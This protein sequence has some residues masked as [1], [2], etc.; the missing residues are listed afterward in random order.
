M[1]LS[2]A[3][4]VESLIRWGRGKQRGNIGRFREK[5]MV[6]VRKVRTLF[7]GGDYF[8]IVFPPGGKGG[9]GRG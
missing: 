6:R 7:K 4:K 1:P 3:S 5:T 2:L 9:W 8:K